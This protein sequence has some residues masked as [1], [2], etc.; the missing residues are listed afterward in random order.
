MMPARWTTAV[1]LMVGVAVVALSDSP[2]ASAPPPAP[3]IAAEVARW[4]AVARSDAQ[5]GEMWKQVGPAVLVEL[6]RADRAIREGRPWFALERLAAVWPNLVGA[7]RADAR[8]AAERRDLAALEWEWRRAG[9]AFRASEA[10]QRDALAA[11]R[12]LAVR[13]LAEAAVSQGRAFYDASLEYGRNT[14]PA[15]GFFYLE[16]ARAQLGFVALCESLARSVPAERG[17]TAEPVRPARTLA[18]EI[19]QLESELLAAYRPPASIDRHGDFIAASGL[20]K[21]ARDL[22]ATGL[23]SGAL[24]RYL[25]ASLRVGLLRPGP[26]PADAP[27]LARAQD[28]AVARLGPGGDSSLLRLFVERGET[29]AAQPG[30]ASARSAAATIASVV[31]PRYLAALAPAAAAAPGPDPAVTITLVRWPFT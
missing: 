10:A 8:P 6:E 12:P 18:V 15:M 29:E 3:A 27:A 30:G 28:D 11:L 25:Q 7:L 23:A 17:A 16:A 19:D 22:D 31:L 14:T 26:D 20:L 13:A 21:E 5:T 9:A 2:A 24:L 1:A 4:L